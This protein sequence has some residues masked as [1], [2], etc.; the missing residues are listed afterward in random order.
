MMARARSPKSIEAEKMY[1]KDMPLVEIAAKLGVPA[2]TVRRWKS[3][4]KWDAASPEDSKKNNPSARKKDAPPKPSARKRGGQPGNRNAAGHGG[5]G[6]PGN[7]NALK[8]GGYAKIFWDSLEDDEM[9]MADTMDDDAEQMLLDE[10]KLLTVR[11]RRIMQRI[12]SFSSLK[13]GQALASV[14]RFEDK[15]EFADQEE[16]EDYENRVRDK[17]AK[18]ERLPGRSYKVS[19]T[20]EG[21]YNIVQRL[22]EA[23]TRCQA[24]KQR[25]IDSLIRL[26]EQNGG[27]GSDLVDDWVN[28]VMEADNETED[29]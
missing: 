14:N 21:T 28:A 4:Q 10:I 1:R 24:Q 18:G 23:L 5:T 9:E 17:V 12:K 22:E 2:S 29:E 27:G 3:D 16:K 13:G 20:T 19:T 15:R 25:C 7:Q 8:H 26:R 6:P 11:E